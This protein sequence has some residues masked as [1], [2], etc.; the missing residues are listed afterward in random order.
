MVDNL[1]IH[2]GRAP[3]CLAALPL[4]NKIFIGGSDGELEHLL[5]H[6]WPLLPKQGIL[7]ASAVTENTKHTY[8]QFAEE[9]TNCITET[10]QITTHKGKQLA[11]QML[12]QPNLT[13]T[14]FKFTKANV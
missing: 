9:Q 5:H 10:L 7:V 13:V 3:N 11:G 4:P 8:L 14:L 2:A 12:Y 1:T 6:C